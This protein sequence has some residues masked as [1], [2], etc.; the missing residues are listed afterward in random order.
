VENNSEQNVEQ[1]TEQVEIIESKSGSAIGPMV[2]PAA[3]VVTNLAELQ[4]T[5]TVPN[6]MAKDNSIAATLA[7][8]AVASG[9]NFAAAS[10]STT[11][12]TATATNQI[13]EADVAQL[14]S[15]AAQATSSE[16]AIIAIV[17]RG[18]RILGVHVEQGVL[19]T[20]TDMDTLVFAI[21]GAVA[22]ARTAAFFSNNDAPLTSRT[23]RFISQSTVTQREVQSNPNL[24]DE[25]ERGPGFV[26]PIGL[27]GHFPPDVLHTPHVDLFAIE[28]TNRDSLVHPGVNRVKEAATVNDEG[29]IIAKGGDDIFLGSRFGAN[30]VEGQEIDA[31]ESYGVVSGTLTHAQSRGIATLPG[32][33]PLFK[34]DPEA[35]SQKLVGG[36]GVFFWCFLSR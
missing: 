22:K 9:A 23:V 16:N 14:L 21:D 24:A 19:D 4:A 3:A 12:E 25:T 11:D 28:H 10:E 26:A 32:G 30:F 33:V 6:P 17:D 27:G 18:G 13:T 5:R 20:I 15:R 29:I 2:T 35:A 1:N 7:N 31:P 36:I 8:F 34:M